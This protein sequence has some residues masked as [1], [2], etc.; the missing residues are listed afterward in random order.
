MCERR[1]VVKEM[2]RGIPQWY[3]GSESKSQK[4]R[5]KVSAVYLL[6][7]GS[8]SRVSSGVAGQLCDTSTDA[9]DALLDR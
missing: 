6:L 3:K 1:S 2:A 7:R 9:S 5:K 4:M 8:S